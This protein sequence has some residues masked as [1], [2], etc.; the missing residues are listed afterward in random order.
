MNKTTSLSRALLAF[1]AL[2]LISA[3]AFAAI[4]IQHWTQPSGAQIYFVESP[5]LPMI[6]MRVDFD[7]GGRRE[8]ADKAGLAGVTS[9]MTSKGVAA[10]GNE[11]A[12]DENQLGE[13]WAD[14]GADFDDGASSD[15]MSFTLR[16]LTYADILP[17]AVTLAARQLG[18]PAFPEDVWQRERQRLQ[19]AIREANTRPGT[20]AGKAYAAAVY[21][22][23]PYGYEMT[24][25]SLAR[26]QVADMRQF[27]RYLEP[28]RAKVSIVGAVSRQQ[29]DQIAAQLLSRL[30]ATVAGKCETLPPVPE[31]APLAAP[32]VKEIPFVSAQ[33]H[34]LMGQPGYKRSDP[35][36]F[37]LL[38]GNYILG[39]SALVS[40]LPI[41]VREKRGLS[42]SAGSSFA[43]GLHAG[44]FTVSLQTRPDQAQQ[45]LQVARDVVARFVADGPTEAELKAAKGFLIGGF[46]L[47]I[48][49]NRKLLENVANIAWNNLPLDYLD[50]WTAHVQAVTAAEVKAAFARK[51]HPDRMVTV[52]VGAQPPH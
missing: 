32:V 18:E 7:A 35:D 25:E 52:I 31:V 40:R 10:H 5:S 37:P 48:D 50:T 51:L 3:R 45:A 19:A 24:E 2:A 33:A 13:A 36:Y 21:G 38:V 26:I 29:A 43:P 11:P 17:K 22:T 46:P 16:T 15:R 14:L 23:H 39:G 34:V 41:E 30:P 47:L 9:G 27:Y 28:C 1:A 49:S 8:P 44:A 4:P 20:V 42:Y 12:L 6:D